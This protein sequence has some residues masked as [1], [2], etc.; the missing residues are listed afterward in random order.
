MSTK[1]LAK[2]TLG[3]SSATFVSRILGLLRDIFSAR[4]FGTSGVWDA[5]LIAFMV[6]NLLRRLLAE[7]AL[8]NSF[9]PVFTEYL[10]KKDKEEAKRLANLT[11]TFLLIILTTIVAGGIFFINL[12]LAKFSFTP[13]IL[14]ILQL[15]RFL[16]PYIFF[17]SLAALLMGILNSHKHFATPA[18]APLFLN[19][20]WLL[21]L[22]YLC[23]RFGKGL[24][25]KIWGV[26]IGVL[27]GGLFQ[28]LI[29]IPPLLR[30]KFS[31][32]LNF[33]FHHPGL[34]KIAL[35]ALPGILGLA[36]TQV[37]IVVDF[38]LGFFLGNGAISSL[39]YGNR[40]MQFPLGVFGI[41][42]GTAV[43]PH[44]SIYA[45][46]QEFGKL[47]KML[48]FA[49][50]MGFFISLPAA[51]GLIILRFPIIKLLFQR[52]AFTALSTSRAANTL[53]FYCLGLFAYSGIKI[54]AP[55][56]YSFQ[57]TRTPVKIAVIAMLANIIL[58]LILMVPLREGGLALATAIS[59]SLNLFLLLFVLRKRI[60][61][62]GGKKI[63]SSFVKVLFSAIIMGIGCKIIFSHLFY[64]F[65]LPALFSIF[66]SILSGI[67]IFMLITFLVKVEE[68]HEILGWIKQA[69]ARIIHT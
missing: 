29:Q 55:V 63:L 64:S 57:D 53:F 51:V 41:A 22:F 54:I 11:F 5:F 56:F 30:R 49:L 46:K 42:L 9:I 38:L 60:G 26:I 25:E 39:W 12:I 47:K 61:N 10:H 48:S 23:P 18:L 52:G 7:G 62:F 33:D 6:P 40:L 27:L 65:N 19:I 3:I 28:L 50:R 69:L 21:S 34:K 15:T 43:L 68:T 13:K 14:L 67:I 17:L 16:L 8:S 24:E 2:S 1:S 66:V 59:S 32:R 37:N 31:L 4:L 58:N 44:Y 36:V 35:L 45:A 20:F